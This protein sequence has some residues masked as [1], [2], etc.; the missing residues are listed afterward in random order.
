MNVRIQ[1]IQINIYQLS[2][3]P[4]DRIRTLI[5]ELNVHYDKVNSYL[6]AKIFGENL[7]AEVI[8]SL[9]KLNEISRLAPYGINNPDSGDFRLGV[10]LLVSVIALLTT[11]AGH[12]STKKNLLDLGWSLHSR[13][14][15]LSYGVLV[16]SAFLYQWLKRKDLV[17]SQNM[18]LW[19]DN[20]SNSNSALIKFEPSDD[21]LNDYFNKN[22]QKTFEYMVFKMGLNKEE[23][24]PFSNQQAIDF[25]HYYQ[26]LSQF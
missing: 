15:N 19:R 20:Y 22:Q 24:N 16:D 8:E 1:A 2:A 9:A 13:L 6:E 21:E 26:T 14:Y 7:D 3:F 11:D 10:D 12:Q 18:P 25:Y 5:S 17:R 4:E 23:I